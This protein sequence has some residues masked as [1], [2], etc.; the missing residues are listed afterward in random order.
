M[1]AEQFAAESAEDDASYQPLLP[2]IGIP[3]INRSAWMKWLSRPDS[4]GQDVVR[5]DGSVRGSAN[6]LVDAFM[7]EPNGDAARRDEHGHAVSNHQGTRMIDLEPLPPVQF[8]REHLKW[9]PLD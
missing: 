4:I 2:L 6:N 7:V 3:G 9:L 5:S 1:S 8:D